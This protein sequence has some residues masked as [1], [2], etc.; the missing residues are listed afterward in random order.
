MPNKNCSGK[1]KYKRG[2]GNDHKEVTTVKRR[3]SGRPRGSKNKPKPPII[4]TTESPSAFKSTVFK[5]AT[6]VDIAQSLISFCN[7]HQR[8]LCILSATGIVTDVT[9]RQ[10]DGTIMVFRGQFAII[11][12]NGLFV[13][14]GSSPSGL[15]N[16]TVFLGRGH[17]RMIGG[18]VVGPLVASAPVMVMAATFSNAIYVTN[19]L[20]NDEDRLFGSFGGGGDDDNASFRS[21]VK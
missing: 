13:P 5:F 9:L 14:P 19:P 11:I 6:G 8:G 2:D 17:G 12:M 10:A 16:L 7:T 4:I 18:K 1:D 21:E 20:S 3:S 15:T